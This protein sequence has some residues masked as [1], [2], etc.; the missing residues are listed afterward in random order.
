VRQACNDQE[1]QGEC[2]NANHEIQDWVGGVYF[3]RD[4]LLDQL[5][6]TNK[7]VSLIEIAVTKRAVTNALENLKANL[8]L[9][10]ECS[11]GLQTQT[12]LAGTWTYCYSPEL[13]HICEDAKAKAPELYNG[14]VPEL[15]NLAKNDPNIIPS[16]VEAFAA[17]MEAGDNTIDINCNATASN[18]LRFNGAKTISSGLAQISVVA[19]V[20][21]FNSL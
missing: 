2:Q 4:T 18:K 16:F 8:G 7:T 3:L 19:A 20:I 10:L 13:L 12:L 11:L 9:H 1:L 14:V 6:Q 21:L 15:Q 5:I 17:G